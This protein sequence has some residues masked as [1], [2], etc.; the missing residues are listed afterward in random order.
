MFAAFLGLALSASTIA[1]TFDD[2]PCAATPVL[3]TLL[4]SLSIKATFFNIGQNVRSNSG[5]PKQVIAAGHEIGNHASDYNGVGSLPEASIRTNLA[6]ANDA[7]T[8]AAGVKP[9]YFR[10]PNLDYGTGAL[11]RVCAELGLAIIGTNVIGQ[12]WNPL[13][14]ATIA[15]NVLNSAHDGG[16]ILLHENPSDAG[17]YQNTRDAVKTIASS[18]KAKGYE[19]TNVSGLAAAKGKTL[20]AGTRYDQIV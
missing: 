1:F 10:A 12:D 5:I 11:A 17:K 2:G 20:V 9:K 8:A 14:A 15:S 13:P 6:S 19:F 4:D 7:I 3:L 16:I 18:L